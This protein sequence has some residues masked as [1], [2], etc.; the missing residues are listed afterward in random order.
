[1]LHKTQAQLRERLCLSLQSGGRDIGIGIWVDGY[2]VVGKRDM[3]VPLALDTCTTTY[4]LPLATYCFLTYCFR[5]KIDILHCMAPNKDVLP[6]FRASPF[7]FRML[8]EKLVDFGDWFD[9]GFDFQFII[10]FAMTYA[11]A[12]AYAMLCPIP[13]MMP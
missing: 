10:S 1:M 11:Y 12:D 7:S 5:K 2:W 9:F 13:E 8:D 6:N 4:Y 3:C